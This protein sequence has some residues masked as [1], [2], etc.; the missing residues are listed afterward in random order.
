MKALSYFTK[1]VAPDVPGCPSIIIER[2]LINAVQEFCKD[3]WVLTADITAEI[4]STDIDTDDNNSVDVNISG[5][6][7]EAS[8]VFPITFP[9]SFTGV[10]DIYRPIA[11]DGFM[12]DGVVRD[13]TYYK[14]VVHNKY[15][16]DINVSYF[17][18]SSNTVITFFPFTGACDIWAKYV[19]MPLKSVE[20]LDDTFYEDHLDAIVSNVKSRLFN[21]PMKQWSNP[22]AAA[23]ERM[24]YR[25]KVAMYK[26]QKNQSFSSKSLHVQWRTFGE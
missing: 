3:T 22:G 25:K 10:S 6:D 11:L 21:M 12:V 14:N 13:L 4:A 23:Y 20:S 18:F 24:N 17:Y 2:E 19:Y 5:T 9:A 7:D 16:P 15:L 26:G 8:M 1:Y